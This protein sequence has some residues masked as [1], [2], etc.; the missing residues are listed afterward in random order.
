MTDPVY[1]KVLS[2]VTLSNSQLIG[3]EGG[4]VD[5]GR[6][7]GGLQR[8]REGREGL[9][10]GVKRAR[11]GLEGEVQCG[12]RFWREGLEGTY[13]GYLGFVSG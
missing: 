2:L 7:G 5:G 12:E 4:G 9:W 11:E 1:L 13:L 6:A 3:G 8:E 10:R